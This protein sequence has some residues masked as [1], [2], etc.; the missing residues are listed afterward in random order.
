MFSSRL[1]AT[2]APN[3]VSQAVAALRQSGAPLLD[4][5]ETNPTVV[6]LPYP[7]DV[8]ASLSDPRARVVRARSARAGRRRG[9]PSPRSTPS[10]RGD[11]ARSDRAD[12]EH[13]AR[14][15]RLLF[16]L[17]CNPGDVV[18][19]P[20]P[21]YP[22]FE[23]LTRPRGRRRAARTALDYHGVL[24]DRSRRASSR[25]STPRARAVLVVSP[26]N[27][28][29]SMLRAD[30]REWLVGRVRATRSLAIIADE[31]FADYPLA[32]RADAVVARRRVARADVRA[33]RPVEVRRPAAGEARLDARRADRRRS[34]TRRSRGSS[35]SA[36]RICP[37]RRPCRS[38]RRG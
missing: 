27:P 28:T 3:L 10:R 2:L 32:P 1:P 9:R 20:Q 17:L 30:D 23:L 38:P 7:D 13:A 25:R 34:P 18:L 29:G 8:L 4:L 37:C 31:V 33:R 35:S 5:T 15:T 11:L 19:V 24:V 36:T 14:P 21:S 22:L 6:G 12:G 26:N 16:K